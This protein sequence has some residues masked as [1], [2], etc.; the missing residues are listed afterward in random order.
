MDVIEGL[1]AEVEHLRQAQE[2]QKSM[3]PTSTRKRLSIASL[4]MI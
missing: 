4:R 1:K 2:A 3:R